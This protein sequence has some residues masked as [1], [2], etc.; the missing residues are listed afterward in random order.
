MCTYVYVC[1]VMYMYGLSTIVLAQ[2]ICTTA[3]WV[4]Y[5]C[6]YAYIYV[7]EIPMWVPL[8]L[9]SAFAQRE[10]EL[11]VNVCL[12]WPVYVYVWYV[13]VYYSA[14]YIYTY[15]YNYSVIKRKYTLIWYWS[16][17]PHHIYIYTCMHDMY[18]HTRSPCTLQIST[19]INKHTHTNDVCAHTHSALDIY[20]HTNTNIRYIY[21]Y[22]H[23]YAHEHAHAR[24]DRSGKTC[25]RHL[26]HQHLLPCLLTCSCQGPWTEKTSKR[27]KS[28][29]CAWN[30]GGKESVMYVCVYFL[31]CLHSLSCVERRMYRDSCVCM[32]KVC[33]MY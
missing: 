30:A 33:Y 7:H 20:K 8:Y 22:I 1:V 26:R 3:E 24:R 27:G 15:T 23:T 9:H 14:I 2:C 32:V 18:A 25:E 11:Y 13:N 31:T 12:H 16:G 17:C 21:I 19:Q 5:P 28:V 29:L 4:L 10:S 6:I